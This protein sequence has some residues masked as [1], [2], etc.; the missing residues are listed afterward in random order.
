MNSIVGM[1]AENIQRP[2]PHT[3]GWG[4]GENMGYLMSILRLPVFL[5]PR[6]LPVGNVFHPNQVLWP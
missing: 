1:G 6:L 2:K 4:L 3:F 5:L